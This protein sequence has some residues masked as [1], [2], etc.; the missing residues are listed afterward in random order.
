MIRGGFRS[1]FAVRRPA[2]GYANGRICA[3]HDVEHWQV[4]HDNP[5]CESNSL[6]AF[7]LFVYRILLTGSFLQSSL[8]LTLSASKLAYSSSSSSRSSSSSK[9]RPASLISTT[10]SLAPSS[11]RQ[12]IPNK[13]RS[14]TADIESI[15]THRAWSV[16]PTPAT[17]P[18]SA[19][20]F[21][22]NSA[23]N[24]INEEAENDEND[25]VADLTAQF[26]NR[27]LTRSTS[28]SRSEPPGAGTTGS[29]GSSVGAAGVS[30]GDFADLQSRASYGPRRSSRAP[31][32]GRGSRL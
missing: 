3:E 20:T 9:S 15:P 1:G 16:T 11:S 23:A 30:G 4:Y 29:R 10:G 12:A 13:S 28:R 7:S 32:S 17:P 14:G 5:Y 24:I 19:F 18:A 27:R 8:I 21:A 6:S 26:I 2:S 25:S 22:P 31:S